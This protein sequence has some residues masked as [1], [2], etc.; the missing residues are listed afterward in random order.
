[1]ISHDFSILPKILGNLGG[2]QICSL[3]TK[4]IILAA[5]IL[6]TILASHMMIN[7]RMQA[8]NMVHSPPNWNYYPCHW[9]DFNDRVGRLLVWSLAHRSKNEKSPAQKN[10]LLVLDDQADITF[11]EPCIH[12]SHGTNKYHLGRLGLLSVSSKVSKVNANIHLLC[13]LYY[14]VWNTGHWQ[15]WSVLTEQS[16]TSE[17]GNMLKQNHSKNMA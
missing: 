12:Y 11:F 8:P 13:K 10:N 15:A 14:E 5:K 9:Q 17:T 4:I 16:W 7:V 6:H 1:M 2:F 3:W